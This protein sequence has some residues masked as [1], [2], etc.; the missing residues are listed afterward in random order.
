VRVDKMEADGPIAAARRTG[1]ET[2]VD[3]VAGEWTDVS[4]KVGE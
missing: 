1:S 3:G 2:E 4:C